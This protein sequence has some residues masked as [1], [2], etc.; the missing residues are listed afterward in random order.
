MSQRDSLI[1]KQVDLEDR[2]SAC[3][4]ESAC[5]AFTCNAEARGAA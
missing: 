1:L 5:L 3:L 2:K 4:T